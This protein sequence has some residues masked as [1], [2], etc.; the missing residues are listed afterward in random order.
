MPGLSGPETRARLRP[1][2]PHARVA[3]LTGYA[4]Q[5]TDGDE[6]VHKP[7]TAETLLSVVQR[8]LASG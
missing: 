2:V 7:V 4:Y 6:V 8:L 1:L 3:Y 5:T